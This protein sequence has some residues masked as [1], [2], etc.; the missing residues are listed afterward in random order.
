M[1]NHLA[2]SPSSRLLLTLTVTLFLTACAP[3]PEVKDKQ[4]TEAEIE[5]LFDRWNN[6]LKSGDAATVAAHYANNAVLLPTVSNKIRT[7]HE[8]IQDYFGYFL[9]MQPNAQ[10]D[11]NHVTIN[12]NIAINAGI[13]TFELTKNGQE[14]KV[15]ARYS[16]VYER[17]NDGEWL[18]INHHSSIMPETIA[19]EPELMEDI[20]VKEG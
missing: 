12:G 16:F 1:T 2:S 15:Q 7:D 6:A 4:A 5:Y 19:T 11:E 20:L 18:I 8:G 13:Y 10:I 17:Q 9:V 14:Q 3:E